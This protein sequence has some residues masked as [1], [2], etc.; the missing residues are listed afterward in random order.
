MLFRG[1]SEEDKLWDDART[2]ANGD[3]ED[4]W[5]DAVGVEVSK[6]LDASLFRVLEWGGMEV[7]NGY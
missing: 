3:V 7:V 1:V 2:R 5:K 6:A 4:A